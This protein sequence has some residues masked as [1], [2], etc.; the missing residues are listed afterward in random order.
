MTLRSVHRATT[1][2]QGQQV[3][4]GALPSVVASVLHQKSW[5]ACA[6]SSIGF[7]RR[8]RA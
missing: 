1:P 4:A 6:R 2:Q 3:I 7:R 5:S 8:G